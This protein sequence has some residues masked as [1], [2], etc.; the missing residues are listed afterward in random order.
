[1]R[2]YEEREDRY[3]S[4]GAKA[5]GAGKQQKGGRLPVRKHVGARE[6][7]MPGKPPA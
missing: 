7:K 5:C 2:S 6:K 1:M 4:D 3:D